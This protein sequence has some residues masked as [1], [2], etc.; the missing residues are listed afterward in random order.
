MSLD[1]QEKKRVTILGCVLALGVCYWV[2]DNVLSA[3]DVPAAST[4][5]RAGSAPIAPITPVPGGGPA[6]SAPTVTRGKARS[7]EFRPVLRSKRLEDRVDVTN[8]D[9]T[10]RLDLLAKVQGVDL[11]GGARNLFQFGQ[12]PAV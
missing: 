5:P 3:P 12:P 6:K 4:T 11:A 10:L 2:Y 8:V 7:E 9:P 1:P